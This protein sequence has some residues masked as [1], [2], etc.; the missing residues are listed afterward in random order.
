M[1]MHNF[2]LF[3]QRAKTSLKYV[4]CLTFPEDTDKKAI[5]NKRA[6]VI[7]EKDY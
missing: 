7:I 6:H 1:F 4:I 3:K 2:L 5:I